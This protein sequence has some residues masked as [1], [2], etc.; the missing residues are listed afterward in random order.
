MQ[1]QKIAKTI[2]KKLAKLLKVH[3]K[4]AK[5]EKKNYL[6]FS[7]NRAPKCNNIY[8]VDKTVYYFGY[9]KVHFAM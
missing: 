8:I 3:N 9:I 2:I 1:N 4:D 7:L 5:L 6:K